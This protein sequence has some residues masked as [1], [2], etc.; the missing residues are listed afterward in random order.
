MLG[1]GI[2]VGYLSQYF[3]LKI[4]LEDELTILR[5]MNSSNDSITFKQEEIDNAT[6]DAYLYALGIILVVLSVAIIHARGFYCAQN[7]GMQARIITTGAIYNKVQSV[8][9]SGPLLI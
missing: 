9:Y 5:N 1:Q 6:R 8:V 3:C 4:T 7:A 2:L